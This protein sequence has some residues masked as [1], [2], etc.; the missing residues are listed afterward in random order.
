MPG[1]GQA[2]KPEGAGT[3]RPVAADGGSIRAY[4][5]RGL[6]G[7]IGPKQSFTSV[8][9]S[10]SFRLICCSRP[11]LPSDGCRLKPPAMASRKSVAGRHRRRSLATLISIDIERYRECP[12]LSAT[13]KRSR[14]K[15]EFQA[16][17]SP[18]EI[19]HPCDLRA[20]LCKP[21]GSPSN[22]RHHDASK[23]RFRGTTFRKRR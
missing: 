9:S 20:V 1:S 23:A 12:H 6:S 13:D 11:G 15:A 22:Q 17:N 5:Q 19:G 8:A 2:Q 16:F 10:D 14:T 7:C 4:R 18:T 3:L 21:R